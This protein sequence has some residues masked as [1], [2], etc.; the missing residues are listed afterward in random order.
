ML[1][2]SVQQPLLRA[3]FVAA[4][5]AP[6]AVFAVPD[7][8]GESLGTCGATISM[9]P[10]KG[11]A[12]LQKVHHS[13]PIPGMYLASSDPAFIDGLM[14]DYVRI[15]GACALSLDGGGLN[16]TMLD[17][18]VAICTAV[19]P[20]RKGA[21]PTITVNYSPWYTKF[22]GKDPTVVGDTEAAELA[23]AAAQLGNLKTWLAGAG[24]QIE[25]G[26]VLIDSEK[27]HFTG[28]STAAFKAALTRKHDLIWNLTR[29][30]FPGVR[31]E[32]YDR[33]AVEK[34]DTNPTWAEGAACTRMGGKVI[35]FPPACSVWRSA[36]GINIHER[37]KMSSPAMAR[38]RVHA[39]GAG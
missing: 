23:Y 26:A 10:L 19:A 14:H 39:R 29:S 20:A 30:V 33:G 35:F 32:L 36:N 17:V 31:I 15:S 8:S 38:H 4:H 5:L 18:C 16:K 3:M 24:G 13:W 7:S 22:A 25:L 11:L 21:R 27:F 28:D 2:K 6:A 37:T 12:E 34:W 1:P 9:N